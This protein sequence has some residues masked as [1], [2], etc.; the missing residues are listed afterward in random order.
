MTDAPATD[1]SATDASAGGDAAAGDAAP[2]DAAPGDAAEDLWRF[3]LDVY[4]RDGVAPACLG[5]QERRGQDVCLLLFALW[6]GAARGRRLD[7]GDLA[8]L[9]AAS[10]PWHGEVVRGLRAVRK[11]LKSGPA[12]AP[13]PA[14][15]ALRARVQAAEIEAERIELAALAAA[16]APSPSGGPP[17]AR[18]EGTARANLVLVCPPE[19]AEDEAAIDL[20][21]RAA[22]C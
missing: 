16:L 9:G 4:G 10:A 13:S 19:G 5:L 22:A 14:T 8:R 12:P 11:R 21:V 2:G 18:D 6:A 20:L 7:E 1:A 17:T 3:V 15:E